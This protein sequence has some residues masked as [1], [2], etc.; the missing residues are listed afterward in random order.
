TKI[1]PLRAL[2][3]GGG[4]TAD[5]AQGILFAAGLPNAS[6]VLPARKADIINLS[7]GSS[8]RT[9]VEESAIA[10]AIAEGVIIV[11]AA[12]NSSTSANFY[13]AA[14][15]GVIGVSAT[16]PQG[17][18]ASYSNFGDYVDVAAPGGEMRD[19]ISFGVLSTVANDSTGTRRPAYAFQQGTSMAAPHAAGVIALMK[20][21]N[22][23]LTSNQVAALLANRSI[24]NKSGATCH[25]A[26]HL[27]HGIIDA[28][29]AV[30]DA[31]AL[32]DDD[33]TIPAI[34]GTSRTQLN[35]GTGS[36]Q[37]FV[38]SNIGGSKVTGLTVTVSSGS[39]WLS[40]VE[41]S[42][43]SEKLGT[44]RATVNRTGL[45]NGRYNGIISVSYRDSATPDETKSLQINLTMQVGAL[46]SPG[47]IAPQYVLLEDAVC[48]EENCVV[49][50]VLADSST[51]GFIFNKVAPG[52][53]R[54][55]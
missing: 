33:A 50:T 12:G 23:S 5:V 11:A 38:L 19:G 29:L 54:I 42:V 32:A 20:A 44:Y 43:N 30:T 48:I 10:A 51:G 1:M 24:A 28:Y 46:A 39:S 3:K 21:A 9:D 15:P 27:A 53:Y 2:G 34:V 41:Q 35:L 47:T 26:T 18:K 14:Y 36:V 4:T 13:P 55:Y 7:L 17:T 52:S 22:P 40:V 45:V 31:L 8:Q 49:D 16:N 25:R 6:G 37:D